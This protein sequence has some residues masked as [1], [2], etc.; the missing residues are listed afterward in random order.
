MVRILLAIFF[1]AVSLWS[2]TIFD[3]E[4]SSFGATGNAGFVGSGGPLQTS[5]LPAF[6]G[7]T[8]FKMFGTYTGRNDGSQACTTCEINATAGG[9][10]RVDGLGEAPYAGDIAVGWFFRVDELTV[11]RTPPG[12]IQDGT[13]NTVI[14][15]EQ[16]PGSVENSQDGGIQDGT[17]NT[18][19]F[20]E[21]PPRRLRDPQDGGI[22]DGTSN[23]ILFGEGTPLDSRDFVYRLVILYGTLSGGIQD[24]TSNTIFLGEGLSAQIAAGN[25]YFGDEISGIASFAFQPLLGPFTLALY[26]T[27]VTV[28]VDRA[29]RLSIPENSIDLNPSPAIPEPSTYGF[30][31][32]G[33]VALAVRQGGRGRQVFRGR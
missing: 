4:S 33:L 14:I 24:G 17:S 20:G 18:I 28:E 19:L 2:N 25:G 30:V 1:G 27:P 26:V 23:T 5:V 22:L 29:I 31:V 15:G 11:Q 6:N 8:G 12:D 16:T 9:T 7:V 32:I 3:V 10:I 13:S 21:L